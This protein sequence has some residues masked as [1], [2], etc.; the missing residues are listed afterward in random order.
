[1]SPTWMKKALEEA[2][3]ALSKDEVPIGC[4]IVYQDTI[5]ASS[6]NQT[7]STQD[8][9]AHA[10]VQAIRQA[11]A[12]LNN[13]RLLET[14]LYIT[15]EPCIMCYGAIIQARIPN[16]IF[17]AY[18]QR[19]GVFSQPKLSNLLSLNHHPSWEG[20]IMEAECATLLTSF[21]KSKR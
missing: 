15:L 14:S 1:M 8:P 20:G 4:V 6:H 3:I 12:H 7:L 17:G 2:H 19:T 10:E 9:T 13:H 18:D 5:I 16:V 21:F 11:A